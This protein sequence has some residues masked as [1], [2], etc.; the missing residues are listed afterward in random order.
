LDTYNVRKGDSLLRTVVKEKGKLKK[1][2][3]RPRQTMLD[4]MMRDGYGKLKE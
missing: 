1:T 4:W 2:R 3:G